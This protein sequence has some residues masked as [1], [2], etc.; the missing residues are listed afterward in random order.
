MEFSIKMNAEETL[1]AA[2]TGALVSFIECIKNKDGVNPKTA[3]HA[4]EELTPK[5]EI[6]KFDS[7]T[8]TIAAGEA[9]KAEA[10]KAEAPKVPTQEKTYTPDELAKAGVSLLDKGKQADLLALLSEFNVAAIPALKPEQ[11]GAFALR[12]REMGAEI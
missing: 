3:A 5:V 7:R 10:P 4:P 12:L 11:Y 8:G 9:P 1:H 6:A 2:E